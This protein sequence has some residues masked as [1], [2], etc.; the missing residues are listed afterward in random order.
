MISVVLLRFHRNNPTI[1]QKN[2]RVIFVEEEFKHK[3][4]IIRIRDI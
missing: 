3:P 2:F 4:L 1:L